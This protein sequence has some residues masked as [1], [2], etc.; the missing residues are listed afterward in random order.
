MY[1][2]EIIPLNFH[3]LLSRLSVGM[4]VPECDEKIISWFEIYVFP[5]IKSS[6]EV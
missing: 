6:E 2:S 3:E 5:K 4:K 1:K